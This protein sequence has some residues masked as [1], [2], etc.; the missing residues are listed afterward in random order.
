MGIELHIDELVLH[1]FAP[2]DR[3]RIAAAVRTELARLMA[4]D[5]QANLLNSPLSLERINAGAFK[6]Q[7]NAKPQAA[8]TQIARAVYR[9]MHREARMAAM[10]SRSQT[11]MGGGH[12]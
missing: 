1:G 9:T 8:G 4:A 5:A 2:R 6:V 10:A 12:R 11:G 3:H 7:P